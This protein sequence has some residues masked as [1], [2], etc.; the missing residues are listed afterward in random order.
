MN[1]QAQES[2][3]L[4]KWECNGTETSS[5]SLGNY[6]EVVAFNAQFT[7]G[8][9]W[10]LLVCIDG[11]CYLAKTL[12]TPGQDTTIVTY[13]GG[14]SGSY[15]INLQIT[16]DWNTAEVSQV[17][18]VNADPNHEADSCLIIPAVITTGI[19]G[20]PIEPDGMPSVYPNPSN[21]LLQIEL[22]ELHDATITITDALGRVVLSQKVNEQRSS[23][24]L[25]QEPK[26]IYL[27]SLQTA[28]GLFSQKLVLE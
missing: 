10:D 15:Y 22:A 11:N 21:G 19:N 6:Q 17:W 28:Q 14:Y 24:D 1:I 16:Q 25:S 7:P 3:V 18:T 4:E 26:G 27:V 20:Y 9:L 2:I 13:A 5:F 8:S 12:D 23:I